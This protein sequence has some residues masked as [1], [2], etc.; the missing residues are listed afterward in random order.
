MKKDFLLLIL[1]IAVGIITSDANA[2]QKTQTKKTT[3]TVSNEV[4]RKA[5]EYEPLGV[6]NLGDIGGTK[7][8]AGNLLDDS[9]F[10]PCR[11]R[12]LYRVTESGEENGKKWVK[13]DGPGTS[14]WLFF[15][16]GTFSGTKFRVYRFVDNNGET[17]YKTRNKDKSLDES[18][19]EKCISLP[20]MTVYPAGTEGLPKGGWCAPAPVT[21]SE[22][23]QMSEEEKNQLKD[24]WRVWYKGEKDLQLDDVVIFEKEFFW[25]DP[26]EFHPR[27][28]EDGII[29]AW[30]KKGPGTFRIVPHTDALPEMDGGRGCLEIKT[31]NGK[32]VL[33]YKLA[34][35]TARKDA[36]WYGTLTE[37][38]KYRYEA[39][40]KGK[41]DVTLT[42]GELNE[43]HSTD[44]Y[45]NQPIGQ[46]FSA[47]DKWKKVGYEFTAPAPGKDGIWGATILVEGEGPV[48]ID[49]AKLQPVYKEGDEN[50]PFVIYQPLFKTLMDNQ[51]DTGRKGACRVWFG[52]N[53]ASMSSLLDWYCES[54]VGFGT[55]IRVKSAAEY[56]LPKALTI[57]EA[58][59]NSPETRMVPWLMG[60]V[61]HTEEE[62]RQ[63]IE[64][65]ASPFDPAKD[66]KDSKPMAYKRY[67]QR[68]H[69]RPW[70]DD[71]REIIIEFGNENWHNRAMADWIGMGRCGAVHQSGRA[72]GLWGAHMIEEMKKSPFYNNKITFVFGGNYHAEIKP[73]GSVVG[74]GQEA[75][76][77]A[78]GANDYHSHATYIG[79]R[80]EMGEA[81]ETK[82]DDNGVQK[83]LL[84]H[85]NGNEKEWEEQEKA[86]KRLREMGFKSRMSAYEGGPSGFGLRAKSKEEDLAGEYYGKSY[87]MGTAI[88]DAW[89]NAWKLGWT[90]QCYLSF[91]QGRWWSSH[92]SMSQ[93]HRPS[94]GWLAQILINKHFANQDMLKTEVQNSPLISVDARTNSELKTKAPVKTTEIP[95]IYAHASGTDKKISVVVSNLDLN[96]AC[97]L[98]INIPLKSVSKITRHYL[99]GEPRDT[100]LDDLK[101]TIDEEKIDTKKFVNGK[102][103]FKAEPGKA[104]IF[105]FEK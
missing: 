26:A 35:G 27:T 67:K 17:H 63:L 61:T 49:N 14:N 19:A 98:E 18:L 95:S 65:L 28:T 80:W 50:K 31:E 45:F 58:T 83:T 102:M 97:N 22:Y 105:V 51:P 62:Y 38:T 43:K 47:S 101:V 42:F 96:K 68:G 44:G 48:Y 3:I 13:L 77:A 78:K 6:N 84:S 4:I 25:P 103:Q 46:K 66:T 86:D 82:I 12:M 10:E 70:I 33:W 29:F 76:V 52:L 23:Q 85:R 39:W 71:F 88:L 89:I 64:Y 20:T 53:S 7:H 59:G 8:A 11:L 72:F 93:G 41:G 90:Y 54:N 75:T 32:A 55:S 94:P 56:T 24:K 79:P 36:F 15:T 81:S 5:N 37:G 2:Q 74:Y 87:A 92:T 73:D 99:K 21:F 1:A 104:S 91:G 30:E 16:D 9:G 69:G 34:G 100:N 60:Q 40:I 57:L